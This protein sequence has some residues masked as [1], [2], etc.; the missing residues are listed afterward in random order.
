MT[1]NVVVPGHGLAFEGAP[2]DHEGNRISIRRGSG[3]GKCS[4]GLLSENLTSANARKAW[5]RQHKANLLAGIQEFG[6]DDH[7]REWG[8][9]AAPG[10]EPWFKTESRAQAI[11]VLRSRQDASLNRQGVIVT[12]T[13]T[14]WLEV[15]VED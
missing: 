11:F 5:H 15:D 12:R 10:E 13:V 7:G 1:A 6:T 3:R 4:C 9:S 8:V 14:P 2:F